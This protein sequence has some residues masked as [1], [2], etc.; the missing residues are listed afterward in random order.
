MFSLLTKEQKDK[1]FNNKVKTGCFYRFYFLT[2]NFYLYTF[3]CLKKL[4]ICITRLKKC[5][6]MNVIRSKKCVE[7]W[8]IRWKKCNFVVGK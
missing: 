7:C 2:I 5:V 6:V 4:D 8:F 1:R 3:F